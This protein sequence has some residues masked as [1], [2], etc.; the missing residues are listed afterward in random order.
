MCAVSILYVA[1]LSSLKMKSDFVIN[2]QIKATFLGYF[3]LFY[4]LPITFN[5]KCED[6]RRKREHF[7]KSVLCIFML[8]TQC[9]LVEYISQYTL[10]G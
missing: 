10:D 7:L 1:T 2:T 4:V 8:I 3:C 9:F 5:K 6:I